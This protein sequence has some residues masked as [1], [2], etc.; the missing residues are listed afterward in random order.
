MLP[1]PFF[2]AGVVGVCSRPS[3]WGSF[4]DC[5]G[6]GGGSVVV[7]L[8]SVVLW[9]TGGH[10]RLFRPWSPCSSPPPPPHAS[11]VFFFSRSLF[12]PRPGGRWPASSPAGVCSGV[13]GV[14]FPPAH[15]WLRGVG[16]PVF[17]A[18]RRWAGRAG[19]SVSYRWVLLASPM[20]L[21]GWGAVRLGGIGA[22]LCGCA[23]LPPAF[24]C[25]PWVAGVR[26]WGGEGC[27]AVS[28]S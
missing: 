22:W 14:C 6:G 1:P 5:G 7:V 21:P 13:S 9:F 25:S 16:G 27:S 2:V 19:L 26:S 20:E 15:W 3:R 24:L 18:G 28:C 12:R 8:R 11:F 23:A 4:V 10:C 17:L